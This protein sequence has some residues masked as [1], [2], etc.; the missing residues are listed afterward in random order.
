MVSSVG[1]FQ[2]QNLHQLCLIN[3]TCPL[4]SAQVISLQGL[5]SAPLSPLFLLLI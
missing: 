3:V 2:E 5:H 4:Y 1:L